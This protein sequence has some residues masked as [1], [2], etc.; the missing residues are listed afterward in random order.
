MERSPLTVLTT[1]NIWAHLQESWDCAIEQKI[2]RKYLT[3]LWWNGSQIRDK[4]EYCCRSITKRINRRDERNN[5]DVIGQIKLESYSSRVSSYSHQKY[6]VGITV[7]TYSFDLKIKSNLLWDST[8]Y[9]TSDVI[10]YFRNKKRI[11]IKCRVF[12]L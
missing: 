9:V 2:S 4:N 5:K 1:A 12:M 6:S 10:G 11:E 8:A 3:L 7:W